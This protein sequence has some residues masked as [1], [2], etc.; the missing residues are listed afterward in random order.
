[1]PPPLFFQ[2]SHT[3]YFG[4]RFKSAAFACS[5]ARPF[6]LQISYSLREGIPMFT[7][8]FRYSMELSTVSFP[9]I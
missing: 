5:M 3:L 4:I 7:P 2:F 9:D 8:V 1:M 6:V